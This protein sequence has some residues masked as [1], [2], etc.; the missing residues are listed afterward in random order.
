LETSGEANNIWLWPDIWPSFVGVG[1]STGTLPPGPGTDIAVFERS[2]C[3][4]N[5]YKLLTPT[6]GLTTFNTILISTLSN[7]SSTAIPGRKFMMPWRATD[8]PG[9]QVGSGP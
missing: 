6:T 5:G 4:A 9:H 7:S 8:M 3:Q 2:L 1:R